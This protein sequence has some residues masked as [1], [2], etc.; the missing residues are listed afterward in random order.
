[1]NVDSV[2]VSSAPGARLHLR[3]FV[4]AGAPVLLVHGAIENGRIFYSRG[5]KGLAPFLQSLGYDVY[6]LDLRGRGSSQPAPQR[7]AHHGQHESI[8]VDLPAASDFILRQRPDAQQIWMSHSWGGVLQMSALARFEHLRERTAAVVHFAV[9]RAITVRSFERLVRVELGWK[10]LLPWV[11]RA[12]GYLPADKLGIGSDIETH[13]SLMASIRWVGTGAWIDPRDGF[14]YG[15]AAQQCAFPPSLW[16][17]GA[18]DTLLGHPQD[19]SRFMG[20]CGVNESSFI[21]LGRGSGA[22]HDYDHIDLLTHEHAP[23]DHFPRV[24]A[25]LNDVMNASLSE[26]SFTAGRETT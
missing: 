4:G 10:R 18:A 14:D 20:E 24:S 3:H 15:S 13:D 26:D 1:M 21:L 7:D 22:L 23:Q 19:V 8:C 2:F 11:T 16:L 25:W 17:T 9:K 6:V 12:L 5:G